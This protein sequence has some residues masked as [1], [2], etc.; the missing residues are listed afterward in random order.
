[1]VCSLRQQGIF[2]SLLPLFRP[3]GEKEATKR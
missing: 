1:V 3:Q 2:H